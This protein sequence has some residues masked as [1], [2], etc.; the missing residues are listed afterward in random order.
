MEEAADRPYGRAAAHLR[1]HHRIRLSKKLLERVTRTVGQFWL[2]RDDR[3]ARRALEGEEGCCREVREA[4]DRCC[5]FA[6]GTMVHVD[7]DWHEVRVGT[8]CSTLG[9]ETEKSSIARFADVERFGADLWRKACRS[10]YRESSMKAFVSDGSHW[11]KGIAEMHFCEAVQILDWYHLA[12]HISL[13]GNEVLGEGT[14]GSQEWAGQ[15]RELLD[16][17]KVEATMNKVEELPGRSPSRRQAKRELITYLTNNRDRVDYPR[18]RQLGLPIGS[19]EVEADCKTIVQGRCKQS[20]MR[21]SKPGAESRVPRD[22][23]D[24]LHATAAS[25]ISGSIHHNP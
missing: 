8:V 17:G 25:T 18:Y 5:V 12:E 19:G 24:V 21:W 22:G 16:G 10:G 23:C 14:Q 3:D 9:R 7:G 4:P 15:M 20:G 6:D 1:R 11:I 2:Q 13:C